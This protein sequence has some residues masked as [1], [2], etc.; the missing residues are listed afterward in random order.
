MANGQGYMD[1]RTRTQASQ[2][3][4]QH[5]FLGILLPQPLEFKLELLEGRN[6]HT[7][8]RMPQDLA[9]KVKKYLLNF[10]KSSSTNEREWSS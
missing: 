3:L 2:L 1:G 10:L 5:A 7:Y 9:Y 6:S 8:Q 4:V